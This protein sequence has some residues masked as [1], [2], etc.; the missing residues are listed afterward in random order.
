MSLLPR[1]CHVTMTSNC[2]SIAP[3]GPEAYPPRSPDFVRV[4][5]SVTK[6]PV[7]PATTLGR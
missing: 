6:A 3:T 4:E 2:L 5:R 7:P 1:W